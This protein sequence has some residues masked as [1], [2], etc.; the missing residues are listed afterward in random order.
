MSKVYSFLWDESGTTAIEYALIAGSISIVFLVAAQSIGT[1][2]NL[3]FTKVEN[4]L[5]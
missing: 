2:V 4:G 3:T 1:T 5:Q